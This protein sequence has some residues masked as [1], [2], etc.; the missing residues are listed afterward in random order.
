MK[1]RHVVG[2]LVAAGIAAGLL[3]SALPSKAMP[4]ETPQLEINVRK[5]S[6]VTSAARRYLG[7]PY[8]HGGR[9]TPGRPGIDA[10]GLIMLSLRDRFGI[11]C[12]NWS[13]RCGE[14]LRQLDKNGGMLT[15]TP[16]DST[17]DGAA[18]K[19][20]KDGDILFFLWP[21][22]S[23]GADTAAAA[24]PSGRPLFIW[25]AAV[26][27]GRGEVIHASDLL[28][29]NDS[30]V[31]AVSVEQLAPLLRRHAFTGFVSVRFTGD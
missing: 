29:R 24:D 5:D 27:C 11:D 4:S 22:C 6:T 21:T 15:I 19:N 30:E 12:N 26:Y 16:S 10:I 18:L 25:H 3:G 9:N 20:L 28:D 2:P 1:K 13:P 14:F 31:N 7:T 8:N 23:A 17:M